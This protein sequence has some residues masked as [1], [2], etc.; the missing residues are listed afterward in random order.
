MDLR[1]AEGTWLNVRPPDPGPRLRGPPLPGRALPRARRAR[2]GRGARLRP[3]YGSK[4][5]LERRPGDPDT[6]S[7]RAIEA[8]QP[9][10]KY[11]PVGRLRFERSFASAWIEQLD[12]LQ[13]RPRHRLQ[14]LAVRPA[15]VL[16]VGTPNRSAIRAVAP[17]RLQPRAQRTAGTPAPPRRGSLASGRRRWVTTLHQARARHRG[18]RPVGWWRSTTPSSAQYEAWGLDT[19]HVEVIPNWAPIDE[20]VPQERDND[21]ADDEPRR[22]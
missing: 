13:T 20:I 3:Q 2:T 17:G 8:P 5:A 21:W 1:P 22:P 15:P 11:T 9:F 10:E 16:A 4:G 6:L 14:R 7:F 19:S 18:S 12:G